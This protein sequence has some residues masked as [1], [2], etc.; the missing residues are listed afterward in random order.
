MGNRYVYIYIGFPLKKNGKK[1][2]FHQVGVLRIFG[3]FG[4][5]VGKSIGMTW[6]VFTRSSDLEGQMMPTLSISFYSQLNLGFAE[7]P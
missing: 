5:C 1:H 3:W 7:E 4:G 2:K 6:G